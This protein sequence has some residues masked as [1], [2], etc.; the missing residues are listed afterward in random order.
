MC[1]GEQ[2]FG[3]NKTRDK[4]WL[5]AEVRSMERD[6]AFCKKVLGREYVEKIL[7]ETSLLSYCSVLSDLESRA[8]SINT[9]R[10]RQQRLAQ[11]T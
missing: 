3:S 2:Y 4:M 7:S 10:R 1:E 8:F 5:D 6:K 11:K 9:V